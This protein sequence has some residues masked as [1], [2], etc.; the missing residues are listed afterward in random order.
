MFIGSVVSVYIFVCYYCG[1]HLKFKS[2]TQSSYHE[3][4]VTGGFSS[5]INISLDLH[6]I[7][8]SMCKLKLGDF[9]KHKR[10]RRLVQISRF[11]IMR[12]DPKNIGSV[13]ESNAN[14]ERSHSHANFSVF[15]ES[16]IEDVFSVPLRI[17]LRNDVQ[18]A[19][20]CQFADL[21]DRST[22]EKSAVL[23]N[24]VRDVKVE[25]NTISS[26]M[27]MFLQKLELEPSSS[28]GTYTVESIHV[29]LV[30]SH[31][32]HM[33]SQHHVATNRPVVIFCVI[34]FRIFRNFSLFHLDNWK[35][36]FA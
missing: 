8:C 11:R 26:F 22:S 19:K 2:F 15:A 4:N 29:A 16:K 36:Y 9:R 32:E 7:R 13:C 21:V 12:I 6:S 24:D 31:I 25:C 34:C 17:N 27:S 23:E 1:A 18:F 30:N 28:N 35:Y 5:F 3:E 20:V 14:F 33:I 10:S